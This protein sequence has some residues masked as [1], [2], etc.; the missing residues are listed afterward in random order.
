MTVKRHFQNIR[1]KSAAIKWP[2]LLFH[3]LGYRFSSS[4]RHHERNRSARVTTHISS[5]FRVCFVC[6]RSGRAFENRN[7]CRHT[8]SDI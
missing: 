7:A 1:A 2:L 6:Y 8:N 4:S 3:W 5:E